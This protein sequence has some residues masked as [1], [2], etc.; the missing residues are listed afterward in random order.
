MKKAIIMLLSG[1]A[2]GL[3]LAPAKGS[4]TLNR[5]TGKLSDLKDRLRDKAE[6][7]FIAEEDTLQKEKLGTVL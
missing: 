5:V 4:E 6:D 7:M 2:I 3:L 1:V